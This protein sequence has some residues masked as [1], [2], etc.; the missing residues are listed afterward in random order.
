LPPTAELAAVS[1]Q[2]G[3]FTP[4]ETGDQGFILAV[5]GT[6]YFPMVNKP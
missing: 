3:L 5:N 4:P 2:A 6:L 1:P